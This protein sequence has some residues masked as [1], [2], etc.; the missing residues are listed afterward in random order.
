MKDC[1]TVTAFSNTTGK[2]EEIPFTI[3]VPGCD[4]VLVAKLKTKYQVKNPAQ[5]I[6]C[7]HHHANQKRVP[8]SHRM[9]GGPTT[10]GIIHQ[11]NIPISGL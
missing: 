9:T 7:I 3:G 2:Y 4:N 11:G 1:H 6:N 8:Y 5:H 10:W